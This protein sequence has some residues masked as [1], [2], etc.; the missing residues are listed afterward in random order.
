MLSSLHRPRTPFCNVF[1]YRLRCNANCTSIR[2]K[3]ND[4]VNYNL[5][6]FTYAVIEN[7]LKKNRRTWSFVCNTIFLFFDLCFFVLCHIGQSFIWHLNMHKNFLIVS[8][9]LFYLLSKYSAKCNYSIDRNLC[10]KTFGF[11]LLT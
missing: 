2:V 1:Q 3:C 9:Q 11:V 7:W 6:L 5:Y 10:N 4:C 8:S